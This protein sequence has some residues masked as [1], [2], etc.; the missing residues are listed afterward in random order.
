MILILISACRCLYWLM[1]VPYADGMYAV[2]ST[3]ALPEQLEY[4]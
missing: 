4:G 2:T 1:P 3:G